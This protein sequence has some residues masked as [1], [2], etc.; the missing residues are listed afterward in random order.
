MRLLT[1]TSLNLLSISL[2]IYLFGV[3]AFYYSLRFQVD[4]NVNKE[5]EKRKY[6]I[7]RQMEEAHDSVSRPPNRNEIMLVTPVEKGG[8]PDRFA[9]T[10]IYNRE[11]Q[12][13][14]LYRQLGFSEV[15]NNQAYD[16]RIFKSLE[17]TDSLIVS[18]IMTMTILVILLIVTLLIVNRYS[19]RLVWSVFYDTVEKINR[20]DL[21]SHEE[22]ALQDSDVREFA[23]LNRVLRTMTERIKNDYLNLKEYTENAS[24]EIQTPLAII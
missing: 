4:S 20:Y 3:I 15:I 11:E 8:A 10:L 14:Q 5:M 22:F 17:E 1:K 7:I 16:I 19:S 13:Y 12:R 2:F 23:D 24:H 9:D 6:S 21:N 18:I